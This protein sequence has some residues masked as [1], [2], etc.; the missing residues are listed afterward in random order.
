MACSVLCRGAIGKHCVCSCG[1]AN[2]AKGA[3][4]ER[5][6]KHGQ[7]A[8]PLGCGQKAPKAEN[9]IETPD[10]VEL[11]GNYYWDKY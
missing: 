1:G 10:P 2:H 11:G 6:E 7:I 5:L 8:L 9:P 4:M 3:P